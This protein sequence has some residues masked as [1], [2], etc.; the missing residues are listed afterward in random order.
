[1]P[2]NWGPWIPN[3][4]SASN[5]EAQERLIAAGFLKAI[6]DGIFGG[7]MMIALI[8]YQRAHKLPATARVD[9]RTQALLFPN[10]IVPTERKKPVRGFLNTFVGSTV[11][12]YLVA[13][14]A[15]YIAAKLGLD[16][17]EGKATIE[18]VV[19]QL[20]GFAMLAWGAQESATPKVVTPEGRVTLSNMSAA[21]QAAARALVTQ[22]K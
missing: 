12:K 17:V 19:A 13:M 15:T 1:M 22:N 8:L 9:E 2:T 7:D 14:A 10:N 4:K 5:F 18:S 3:I 16:P 21:D 6:P 11:F 20:V